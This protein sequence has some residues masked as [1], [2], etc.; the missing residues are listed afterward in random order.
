MSGTKTLYLNGI[1]VGTVP[2]TGDHIRD[3]EVARA[4]FAER[5]IIHEPTLVQAMFRQAVSFA[6]TSSYLYDR[7]LKSAPR[8]GFSVAPFVVNSALS[9]ELYLKTLAQMHSGPAAHRHKLVKLFDALPA[10]A[11]ETIKASVAKWGDRHVADVAGVRSV[12]S[13]LNNAFV[14]WR[15]CYELERTNAVRIGATI[16]AMKVLHEVCTESGGSNL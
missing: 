4:F 15:Y 3:M 5:G 2:A 16:T 1:A 7:D 11:R 8:N 9:L 10:Q 13:D 12:L 6:T 14:E